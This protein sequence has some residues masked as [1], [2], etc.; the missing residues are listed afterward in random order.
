MVFPVVAPA[1][2]LHT[3][4]EYRF[5][6]F[7]LAPSMFMDDIL[8]FWQKSI[9]EPFC[10]NFPAMAENC[11]ANVTTW[12][13]LPR[14]ATNLGYLYAPLLQLRNW[15]WLQ[16][17]NRQVPFSYFLQQNDDIQLMLE[18]SDFRE[19]D[20]STISFLPFL[21]WVARWGP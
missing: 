8:F 16:D 12:R 7:P 14:E 9:P 4:Y 1:M 6:C 20:L 13:D 19:Q 11:G 17:L 15:G 3:V 10:V 5:Q 21:S 2:W 18:V